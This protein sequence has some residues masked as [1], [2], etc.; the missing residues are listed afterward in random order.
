[1]IADLTEHGLDFKKRAIILNTLPALSPKC[2][3]DFIFHS[4]PHLSY[5]EFMSPFYSGSQEERKE[6]R[7]LMEE[8]TYRVLDAPCPMCG[9][10][11]KLLPWR[12][13]TGYCSDCALDVNIRYDT[14]R[15][16]ETFNFIPRDRTQWIL[17]IWNRCY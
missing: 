16:K 15:Y 7:F 10:V 3:A 14:K 4:V 13:L 5:R 6:K 9:K 17:D 11:V 12:N 1:M 8:E 2:T